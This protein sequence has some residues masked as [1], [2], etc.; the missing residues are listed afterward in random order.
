M[1]AVATLLERWCRL[2]AIRRSVSRYP[3]PSRSS[4]N[5]SIGMHLGQYGRGIG[6]NVDLRPSATSG[7]SFPMRNL[8]AAGRLPLSCGTGRLVVLCASARMRKQRSPTAITFLLDSAGQEATA[9]KER[10]F[11]GSFAREILY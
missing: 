10:V 5:G 8:C 9:G 4:V 2:T 1:V 7:D 6:H 11:S 3:T